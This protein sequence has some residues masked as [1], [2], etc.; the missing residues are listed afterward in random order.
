MFGAVLAEP[1]RIISN[2]VELLFSRLHRQWKDTLAEL[3]CSGRCSDAF[4]VMRL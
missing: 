1:C 2:V 3:R 4:A